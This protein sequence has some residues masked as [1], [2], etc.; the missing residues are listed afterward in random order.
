MQLAQ[1]ELVCGL[2]LK[3]VLDKLLP[4]RNRSASFAVDS[5]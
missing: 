2:S 4:L 3:S 1:A 5:F